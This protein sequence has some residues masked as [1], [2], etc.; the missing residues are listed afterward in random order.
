MV[1]RHRPIVASHVPVKLVVIFEKACAVANRVIDLDGAGSIDRIGN[2]NL[3]IAKTVRSGRL[4]FQ[5]AAAAVR[6]PG[7]VQKQSVVRSPRSRIFDWDEAVNA[8]PLAVKSK[9]NAFMDRGRP[10]FMNRDSVAEVANP[11]AAA[12]ERRGEDDQQK[13]GH[14]GPVET[15]LAAS[16]TT[17]KPT[18]CH[19]EERKR[20]GISVLPSPAKNVDPSPCSR[21]QQ[22][23]G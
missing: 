13:T 22:H 16:Q 7:D 8:V 6:H 23:N 3:Q 1:D 18:L 9:R 17:D 10:V 5:L 21:W 4:I 11:P 14:S 15:P 19:S 20:R 2:E 12:E